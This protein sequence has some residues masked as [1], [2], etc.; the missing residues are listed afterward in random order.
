MVVW[1]K[2]SD[3]MFSLGP[4]FESMEKLR[5]FG[6]DPLHAKYVHPFDTESGEW[7]VIL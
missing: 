7:E 6:I 3:T 5:A 2:Y 4:D 1:T